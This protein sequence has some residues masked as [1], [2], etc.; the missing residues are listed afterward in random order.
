VDLGS[1]QPIGQVALGSWHEV[2][3]WIHAPKQVAISTS[4]DGRTWTPYATVTTPKD[5]KGRTVFHAA[6][7]ARGRYVRLQVTHAGTILEGLPGAGSPSWLFLDEI[8][9]K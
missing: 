9:V 2:Y 7:K 6:A 5:A 3:A 4:T 8:E 1:E